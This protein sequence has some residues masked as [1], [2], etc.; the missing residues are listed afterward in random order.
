MEFNGINVKGMTIQEAQDLAAKEVA[1]AERAQRVHETREVINT[2]V[3]VVLA[4]A[5]GYAVYS[6]NWLS[7]A[8]ALLASYVVLE[9]QRAIIS[10]K[11]LLANDLARAKALQ[12]S[13][14]AA[15]RMCSAAQDSEIAVDTKD[16]A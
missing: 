3:L 1:A 12:A 9:R 16:V 11:T 14:S 8:L 13:I 4:V 7:L 10:F 5:L 15:S 2:F 6:L